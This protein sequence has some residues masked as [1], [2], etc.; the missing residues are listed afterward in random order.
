MGDSPPN[1][2]ASSASG[3][4]EKTPLVHLVLYALQNGLTG[5][6]EVWAA[7]GRRA[8]L[9]FLA[10]QPAKTYTS[11]P[12]SHLGSVMHELG[13]L[14]SERLAASL[15]E[16][17]EAKSRGPALHG[18][19]LLAARI[20]DQDMLRASLRHQVAQ[21]LRHISSFPPSS[22]YAYYDL[23]D[24]LRGWG[25][26]MDEGFDPVPMVLGMLQANPPHAHLDAALA[27][28]G[29]LPVRLNRNANV[30]RLSL[31]PTQ[32]AIVERLSEKPLR[33]SD[34]MSD[35]ELSE[36][37]VRLLVYLL[38]VTRHVE[39]VRA[40]EVHASGSYP[41][42]RMSP[43]PKGE[44][45][46]PPAT[47][48]MPLRPAPVPGEP[49]SPVPPAVSTSQLPKATAT[50]PRYSAP[51]PD[52]SA[53]RPPKATPSLPP[54]VAQRWQEIVQRAATI[55]RDDYFAMLDVPR[56]ATLDAVKESFFTL[57]KKWHPDRLPPELATVRDACSRV[58]A[59][60][61]EAHSTLTDPTKRDNYMML[62]ADG[63]GSPE[64]Q[65]KVAKVIDAATNFQKAEVCLRRGDLAQAEALCQLALSADSTQ[66]DYLAM[67]A[68][69]LALKPENQSA[70]KGAQSVVMLTE[71]IKLNP[72][73]EMAFFWRGMVLRRLGKADAAV[74]DFKEVVDLNPRNIDAA[75]EVRLYRMRG[76]RFSTSP[77]D[78]KG[79]SG[80][81]ARRSSPMPSKSGG[82]GK[83][84]ILNRLFKK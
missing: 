7:D 48:T 27:G 39:V 22:A 5:T 37:D 77:P 51:A 75:R 46:P 33:L 16:L 35:S 4:L 84:G 59:R 12:I 42:P 17:A 18:Q 61:S 6:M 32:L 81:P 36:P 45:R 2:P 29:K 82:D 62:L 11:E 60:M 38:L 19:I 44:S 56:N 69:L 47:R 13:Y 50:L 70:E 25:P 1:R 41:A 74:R 68:W 8:G 67:M 83:P 28:V 14:S 57:A 31:T 73:C 66:S 24:G 53:S 9:L 63:S 52:S 76:G 72:R 80:S 20:I 3:T 23:F 43:F 54:D 34:L 49:S 64:T 30:A 10:G 65:E 15:E 58:F 21:K 71:A 26:D 55:D 40:A 78:T 79:D